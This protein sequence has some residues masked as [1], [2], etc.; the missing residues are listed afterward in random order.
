MESDIDSLGL[1]GDGEA[2]KFNEEGSFIG[3]VGGNDDFE[4]ST[5]SS[6][7]ASCFFRFCF[8]LVSCFVSEVSF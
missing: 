1:Y 2:G 3:Q 8:V 7:N 4:S 6:C 5:F